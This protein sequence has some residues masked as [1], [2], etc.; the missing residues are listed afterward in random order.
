MTDKNPPQ[1]DFNRITFPTARITLG[2]MMQ[3]DAHLFTDDGIENRIS[4]L[5]AVAVLLSERAIAEQA[6][7]AT[8]RL[9][10]PHDSDDPKYLASIV[11]EAYVDL[12]LAPG[13]QAAR[14]M[15]KDVKRQ[16][17]KQA[18]EHQR[19]REP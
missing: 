13:L 16:A 6:F 15:V 4:D 17:I 9:P 12:G 18:R 10:D 3:R 2:Q 7:A 19:G 14:E 8:L 11:A 1:C 5:E